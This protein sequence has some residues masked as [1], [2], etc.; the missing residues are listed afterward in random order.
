MLLGMPFL[1]ATNP[2][3]DWT[4]GTFKGKVVAISMDA[5]KWKLDQDS[6]VFKPFVIQPFQ[7]YRHYEHSNDPH[8]FINIDPDNY[9]SHIDPDTSTYL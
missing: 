9:I 6:K 4:Q 5:H 1:T 2:N 8:H 7:G 3:I